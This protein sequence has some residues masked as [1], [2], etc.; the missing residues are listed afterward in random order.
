MYPQR[1]L[2]LV[3]KKEYGRGTGTTL[4][5]AKEEASRQVLRTIYGDRVK[6]RVGSTS[7]GVPTSE[8]RYS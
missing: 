5:A 6:N 2:I 1:M 4:A 3:D 8:Q 7:T